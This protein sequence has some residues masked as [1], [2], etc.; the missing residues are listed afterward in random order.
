[1]KLN[2]KVNYPLLVL[3]GKV[4]VDTIDGG[5]IR[6]SVPEYSD[7]GGHLRIQGKGMKFFNEDK[8]GDI[9]I[10]LGVETPK[11]LDDDTKSLLI[12]L[13]EKLEKNVGTIEN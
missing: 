12:D 9:H 11:E 5:K 3:G 10:T 2:L 7:V 8:R 1:L 4:E 6:V 13:K